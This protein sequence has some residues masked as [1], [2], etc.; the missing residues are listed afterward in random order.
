MKRYLSTLVIPQLLHAPVWKEVD[1]S[2]QLVLQFL[3]LTNNPSKCK[4]LTI[5]KRGNHDLYSSI[6]MIPSCKEVEILG[7][8]FQCDS[9][10]PCRVIGHSALDFQYIFFPANFAMFAPSAQSRLQSQ[11]R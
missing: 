9:K 3:D 6:G 2:N 7:V 8:T 4:E 1:Y 5:K 11:W 10:T